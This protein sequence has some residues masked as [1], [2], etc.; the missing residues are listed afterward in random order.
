MM[1][2]YNIFYTIVSL[3]CSDYFT[4]E[5]V[6]LQRTSEFFPILYPETEVEE[7]LRFASTRR[8]V[9]CK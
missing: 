8:M 7:E 1:P 3:L 4:P 5:A 2:I 6:R 9:N